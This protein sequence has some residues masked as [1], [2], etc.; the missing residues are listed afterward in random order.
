[1]ITIQNTPKDK[2][3]IERLGHAITTTVRV[4]FSKETYIGL[5]Q[6]IVRLF[7]WMG[8]S[9]QTA[10]KAFWTPKQQT[11]VATAMPEQSN[12]S[13]AMPV[14]KKNEIVHLQPILPR[15]LLNHVCGFLTESELIDV[16]SVSKAFYQ[17]ASDQRDQTTKVAIQNILLFKF[18]WDRTLVADTLS[19]LLADKRF[20]ESMWLN[21]LAY[22]QLRHQATEELQG[23]GYPNHLIKAIRAEILWASPTVNIPHVRDYLDYFFPNHV[24][25]GIS[26][27][28]DLAGRPAIFFKFDIVC[29]DNTRYTEVSVHHRR[30]IHHNAH[31]VQAGNHHRDAVFM[32]SIEGR[33]FHNLNEA[34]QH[35]QPLG[36]LLTAYALSIRKNKPME[37][38]LVE[39]R[40]SYNNGNAIEPEYRRVSL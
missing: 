11:N 25:K 5:A 33:A 38:V 8:S 12:V 3:L 20:A 18:Q 13:T 16:S 32:G 29:N 15:D 39:R 9:I 6:N 14:V 1:M 34:Y 19:K 24:Q 36:Q 21:I 40:F 4:L 31:W 27:G 26:R 10:W 2:T 23:L 35:D 28:V 17:S 7:L 30:Y 22:Q 37:P